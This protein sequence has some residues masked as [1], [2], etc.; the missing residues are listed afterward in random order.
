MHILIILL[1][2]ILPLF[3]SN[4]QL[5]LVHA[6]KS[7][8]KIINGERVKILS[9]NVEAY[10][11]TL[12]MLCDEAYFYEE[13]NLYKFIGNVF[14]DDGVHTLQAGRIDYL[15]ETRTAICRINVRISGDNDSLYAEKFTYSFETKNAQAKQNLFIWDK[16]NDTWIWGDKGWYYSQQQYSRVLGNAHFMHFNP[17]EPDTL[18]ITSRLMEYQGGDANYAMATDSVR[19]AKGDLR[20]TCD[21][22]YYD[23]VQEKIHLKINPIAW[24]AENE[25]Q[26]D[27]IDLIL[28]SLKIETILIKE[29]AQLKS[30]SD[31]LASAYDYLRGKSIEV[32]MK[33]GKPDLITARDNASSIYLLKD[34]EEKQGTNVASSDS[35]LIYFK[36]GVMDSIAIIGG[37]QGTFYPPDYKGEMNGE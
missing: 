16:K 22:A 1:I 19:I 4:S 25:M 3:A 34:E 14:I 13:R 8:G 15:P 21:S 28:D 35:I 32:F 11:D 12:R 9:G 26:G 18:N 37:A 10:Q 20:A 29:N 2:I 31:S 23:L 6:D 36:E 7:I 33:N 24:Q 30:M 5:R 17:G 27:F